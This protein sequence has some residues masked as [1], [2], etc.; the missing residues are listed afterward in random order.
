MKIRL[1]VTLVIGVMLLVCG[2]VSFGQSDLCNNLDQKP[3]LSI[4]QLNMS[5]LV[6]YI[7]EIDPNLERPAASSPEDLYQKERQMLLDAGYPAAFSQTEPD[8]L[9]TRRLFAQ[10]MFQVATEFDSDFAANYGGITNE[11][12]ML[13]ALVNSGWLYQTEGNIYR[14][15]IL[16]VLCSKLP[17]KPLISVDLSPI[18][19]IDAEIELPASPR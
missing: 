11:T 4:D 18:M 15:E 6:D 3:V 13:Q 8:T 2:S 16:T 17:T 9:V 7:I 14:D 5:D 12:E 1:F 10:I 19:L